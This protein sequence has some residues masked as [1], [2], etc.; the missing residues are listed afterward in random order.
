MESNDF[1]KLPVIKK[2]DLLASLRQD[3]G[4]VAN[5]GLPG[6]NDRLEEIKKLDILASIGEED[7]DLG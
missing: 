5:D 2:E 4:I 7:E 3:Q 1:R 6:V